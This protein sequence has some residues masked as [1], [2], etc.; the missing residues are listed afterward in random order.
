MRAADKRI[1]RGLVAVAVLM[2]A[3]PAWA[4]GGVVLEAFTDHRP[5]DAS[6]LLGP[7]LDELAAR[8]FSAGDTVA[9]QYEGQVSRAARSSSGLP[10]DFAVQI[11]NGQKAWVRGQFD[12]AIKILQPLVD[13]AH[14]N[15]GAFVKDPSLREPLVKAL[16]VLAIAQQR[17]GD[18]S[19]ARATFGEL[20]RS[21]PESQVS[22]GTYG[23][24][25]ANLFDEVKR[26]LSSGGK[27][28]LTVKADDGAVVFVDEVF[29][30]T[31]TTELVGGEYRVS[32]MLNKQP[33]RSHRVIVKPGQEATIAIDAGLDQAIHIN[34]WTGLLFESQ[35][36]REAHEGQFAA[37]VATAIG[38][39]AVAVV[40]IEDVR[41]R[42]AVV[43][44][45]ISLSS[46]REI[47]RASIAMEPDPSTDRLKALAQYL[48]GEEPAGGM[49]DVQ[50]LEQGPVEAGH[51]PVVHHDGGETPVKGRWGGWKWITGGVAVAGL[52]TGAVLLGLDGRCSN[53]PP[54][55]QLCNVYATKTPGF[56]ALAGGAVFA[57]ISIYLF[58]TQPKDPAK[59]AFI[60]PTP[61]G[62]IAGL[63]GTW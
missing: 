1:M 37:E 57:G 12:E 44:S 3:A 28:K 42:P 8:G 29:R 14:A 27:G 16:T 35:A 17:T 11:D 34:G 6:R 33:S 21:A 49:I 19:A 26:E 45:L 31:S 55:G 2:V 25:A 63:A 4:G 46:G 56:A 39:N 61:D 47:R 60:V 36:D 41:G 32:V 7:V 13:A 51:G 50:P 5:P 30:G 24:D 38:A 48:A 23:P 20:L 22:R 54:A 58:A 40:G 18:P 9:R 59:T 10:G 43:G 15:T 53:S 52:G 62:A